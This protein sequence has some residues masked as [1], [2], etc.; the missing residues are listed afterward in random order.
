MNLVLN[1]A[2]VLISTFDLTPLLIGQYTLKRIRI[3]H[4]QYLMAQTQA[5]PHLQRTPERRGEG[6]Y[7]RVPEDF[8]R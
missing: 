2:T 8:T 3:P 6:Q 7:A 4:I 5:T 1:L